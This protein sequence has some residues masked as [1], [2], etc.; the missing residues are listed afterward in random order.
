MRRLVPKRDKHVRRKLLVLVLVLVAVLTATGV[1][2]AA[3]SGFS[4]QNA[5]SPNAHRINQ[6]YWLIFGFTAVIFV[7]V[8]TALVVFIVRYRSRGRARTVDGAQLHGHARIEII[9]T[10]IPIAII[11]VIFS[12]VF[13]KLPGISGPPKASASNGPVQIRVDAHQFYW[14][15]TYPNGAVSIDQLHLPVGRVADLSINSEDVIHSWWIPQ[16]GGKTDAIPGKT[17]HTW[18]RPDKIG[19]YMGQCAEFCGLYHERMLALTVVTSEADYR[20]F[21]NGGATTALGKAEWLG[22]CAKCHGALGQ[23]GYGPPLASNPILTQP[24]GLEAIIH[25]GR[26]L[27]PDVGNNWTPQQLH[28]LEGYLKAHVYKAGSATGGG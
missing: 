12:F 13:Y 27:M 23:G 22:T 24:A 16:L 4:P 11:V 26:G 2:A 14:Q 28:A 18:Y 1:A 8:E 25:N 15:F 10:A 6:A 3:N 21:V 19:T 7:I 5:H 9:W 17:N 20:R